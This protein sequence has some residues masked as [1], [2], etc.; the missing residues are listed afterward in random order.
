MYREP[1]AEAGPGLAIMSLGSCQSVGGQGCKAISSPE[2][3]YA[4]P[5]K[6]EVIRLL[7]AHLVRDQL[8]QALVELQQSICFV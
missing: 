5:Q 4:K 7:P 2:L 3:H 1:P 6:P 8:H